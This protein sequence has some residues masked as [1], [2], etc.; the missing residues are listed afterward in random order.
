MKC[1]P[2]RV[3]VGNLLQS[4]TKDHIY[5]TFSECGKIKEVSLKYATGM[6]FAFVEFYTETDAMQAIKMRNGYKFKGCVFRVEMP[7]AAAAIAGKARNGAKVYRL[8]VRGLSRDASWQ[9]IKD[10]FEKFAPVSYADSLPDGTKVLE[11][12]SA[13]VAESVIKEFEG[14]SYTTRKGVKCYMKITSDFEDT[15]DPWMG[16]PEVR[17]GYVV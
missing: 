9:E 7:R 13:S 2:C 3:Y 14:S 16:F 15:Q 1:D 17:P 4:I 6:Y 5:D 11:Y 8:L 12:T 10:H